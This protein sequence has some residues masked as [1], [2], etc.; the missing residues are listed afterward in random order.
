MRA[1]KKYKSKIMEAI[2]QAARDLFDAGLI[3]ARTMRKFDK[4]CLSPEDV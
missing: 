1:A 2:H 3:D 4:S